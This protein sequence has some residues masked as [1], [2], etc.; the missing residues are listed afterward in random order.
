MAT[1]TPVR[2][3]GPVLSTEVRT[4]PAKDGSRNYTFRTANIL[5]GNKGCT[6]LTYRDDQ[7]GAFP[8]EGELVD[9]L[10]KAGVYNGDPQ[11]DFFCQ[12]EDPYASSKS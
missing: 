3:T 5:V 6:E 10:A 1:I 8:T 2:I 7:A 4:V 11:F 12:F 9:V